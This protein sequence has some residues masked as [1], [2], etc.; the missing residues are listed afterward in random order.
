[1][2]RY[3]KAILAV[4]IATSLAIGAGAVSASAATDKKTETVKPK[5]HVVHIVAPKRQTV[6][7]T[8]PHAAVAKATPGS[9][10]QSPGPTAPKKALSV[11]AAHPHA[12]PPKLAVTFGRAMSPGQAHGVGTVAVHYTQAE[13]HLQLQP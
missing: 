5:P 8:T 1:M 6:H 2:H 11:A 3:A 10:A 13:Y 4:T 9:V 12:P 7:V